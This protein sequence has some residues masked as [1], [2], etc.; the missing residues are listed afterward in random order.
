[1]AKKNGNGNSMEEALWNSAI[2][3]RGTVESGERDK[4]GKPGGRY[5]NKETQSLDSQSIGFKYSRGE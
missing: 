2:K 4:Q 3:L 1:M 5:E